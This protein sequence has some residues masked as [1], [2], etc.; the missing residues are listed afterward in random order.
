MP[1]GTLPGKQVTQLPQRWF[2]T[3]YGMGS[4][5]ETIKKLYKLWNYAV[6]DLKQTGAKIFGPTK[7]LSLLEKHKIDHL[8]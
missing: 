5:H 8:P 1:N 3:G 2:V 4:A 7:N 6:S